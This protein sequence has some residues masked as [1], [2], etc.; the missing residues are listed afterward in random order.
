MNVKISDI[1]RNNIPVLFYCCRWLGFRLEE[2]GAVIVLAASMFSVLE[3]NNINGAL[4]GLSVSYALQ[5]NT[6][7]YI[8]P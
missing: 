2:M 6:L 7:T 1:E 4:V 3:R 8:Y 5:V